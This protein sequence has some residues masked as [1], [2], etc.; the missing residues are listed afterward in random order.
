MDRG[1]IGSVWR[2]RAGSCKAG[3][4]RAVWERVG[5]DSARQSGTEQRETEPPGRTGQ[6][7]EVSVCAGQDWAKPN[8]ACHSQQNWTG[9]AGRAVLDSTWQGRIGQGQFGYG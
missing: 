9:A 3:H 2:D 4:G 5:Q 7:H 1:R 6:G 8:R